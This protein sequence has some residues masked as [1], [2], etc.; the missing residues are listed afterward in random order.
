MHL[1]HLLSVM[2]HLL[3]FISNSEPIADMVDVGTG[4]PFQAE[5]ASVLQDAGKGRRWLSS[6]L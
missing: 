1:I 6:N 3:Y 4:K 5:Q 2:S